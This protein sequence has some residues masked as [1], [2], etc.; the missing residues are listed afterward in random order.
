MKPGFLKFAVCAVFLAGWVR[1]D[2]LDDAQSAYEKGNY[3]DAAKLYG[4]AAESM[5]PNAGVY[6]NYGQAL[7]KDGKTVDAVLN[8]RRAFLL[9][10]ES[11]RV[12]VALDQANQILGIQAPAP[13]WLQTAVGYLPVRDVIYGG[14]ILAWAGLFFLTTAFFRQRP[15]RLALPAL[16]L[17]AGMAIVAA[18]ALSDPRLID[19]SQAVV[20]A[21]GGTAVLAEPVDHSDEVASLPAGSPVWVLLQ[22]GRWSYCRL[23]GG[24]TG[25][26]VSDKAT[27]VVPKA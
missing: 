9:D 3:A 13:T 21:D 6:F 25:W 5:H 22:R 23:A 1:A 17:I 27:P 20:T 24:V 7:F 14:S 26:L 16:A 4:Q 15:R 12:R 2:T 19:A 18:G 10:P 8:F 11:A